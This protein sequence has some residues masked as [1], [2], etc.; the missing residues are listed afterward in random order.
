VTGTN[1]YDDRWHDRADAY[2]ETFPVQGYNVAEEAKARDA[3]DLFL[4]DMESGSG[5]TPEGS[6]H[7]HEM[8]DY[9]GID[10]RDF[11]WDDFRDWYDES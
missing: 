3:F 6:I 11:D 5:I 2:F 8:L 10:P 4:R 7:W 1:A 9:M